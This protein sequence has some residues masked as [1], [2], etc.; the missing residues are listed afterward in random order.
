MV[1]FFVQDA[2]EPNHYHH[3]KL[4]VAIPLLLFLWV[5]RIWL[6]AHRGQMNDDPASF[7]IGDK[8]S[9]SLG[10]AI[11]TIFIMAL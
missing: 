3:P 7:A 1:L 6:L 5:S 9:L 4:L 11:G 10:A 2:Q 8:I